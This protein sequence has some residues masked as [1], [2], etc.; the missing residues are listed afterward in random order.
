MVITTIRIAKNRF[1]TFLNHYTLTGISWFIFIILSKYFN[2]YQIDVSDD[3]YAIFLI[4]QIFYC[5]TVFFVKEQGHKDIYIPIID[6][7]RRRILEI[8]LLI[9]LIPAAYLNYKLIMSGV[10]LWQL[11]SDYWDNQ[12]GGGDYLILQFQQAIIG[13]FSLVIM[14][15]SFYSQ[16]SNH[17]NKSNLISVF[18]AFLIGLS[19]ML[20]QGGGRS[21][22]MMVVYIAFLAFLAS[23]VY[24]CKNFVFKLSNA[25]Y[26]ILILV[27]VLLISWANVGRGKSGD[28]IKEAI[29]GQIIFAPLFEYYYSC[30]SVFNE[31]LLGCSMFEPIITAI[32]YPLKMLFNVQFYKVYNNDL[33]Q[34]FIFLSAYGKEYNAGVS[35]YW[36]YMRDFGYLGVVLGPIIT[37]GIYNVLHSFCRK[38][39]FYYVFYICVVLKGCFAV[40]YPFGKSFFIAFIMMLL[41]FKFIKKREV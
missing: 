41:T 25:Y 27:C 13:P 7:N 8:L 31:Y 40:G 3:I 38:N 12:H 39:A 24:Y 16:I 18:I 10:E 36:Y 5:L 11:N 21:Q 29:N 14:G 32:Q 30:T 4:G 9:C 2:N 1:G 6:I 33:V 22:V 15:T 19:Y 28:F 37:A 20:I 26:V 35:A 23:K 17:Q 34:D